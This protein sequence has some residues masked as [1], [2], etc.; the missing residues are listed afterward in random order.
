MRAR[1]PPRRVKV[2][3]GKSTATT[4]LAAKRQ[5]W[6]TLAIHRFDHGDSMFVEIA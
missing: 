6:L 1:V 2:S 4:L 3:S 5:M